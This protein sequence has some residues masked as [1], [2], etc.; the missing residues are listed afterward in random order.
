MIKKNI[1]DLDPVAYTQLTKQKLQHNH[2][3]FFNTSLIEQRMYDE[4]IVPILEYA[5]C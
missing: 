3:L 5:S 2:A 4:V 1:Q